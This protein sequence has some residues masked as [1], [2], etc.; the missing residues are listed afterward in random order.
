MICRKRGVFTKV[1]IFKGEGWVRKYPVK[2]KRW[3]MVSINNWKRAFKAKTVG[4][5]I[6]LLVGINGNDG[7][8]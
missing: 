4:G 7:D 1:E 8:T 3:D 6:R 2:S 5:P